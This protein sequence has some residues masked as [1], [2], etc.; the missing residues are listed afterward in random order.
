MNQKDFQLKDK[1]DKNYQLLVDYIT[2]EG[3]AA[4]IVH[5]QPFVGYQ[6]EDD[7][8]NIYDAVWLKENSVLLG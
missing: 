5:D 2:D 7:D 8:G 3:D 6:G 4:L 1:E